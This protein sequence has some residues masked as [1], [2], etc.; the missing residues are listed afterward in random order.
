M[1][2]CKMRYAIYFTPPDRN[3]LTVMAERW[4]GRS[5]FTEALSVP[6]AVEE[7]SQPAIE[8]YTAEPRRYGFHA[9]LKAP[10]RLAE[11][12]GEAE[13]DAAL[14]VFA[15]SR[16]PFSQKMKISR[17]GQFFAI[18]PDGASPAVDQ[19]ANEIV[20]RFEPFR[21]PLTPSEIERRNPDRLSPSQLRN[22]QM[23]GYPHVFDD[24]RFHITLTGRVPE[25]DAEKMQTVLE[26][27]F[28]PLLEE[29]LEIGTLALFVEQEGSFFVKS[30]HTVGGT[31]QKR[32]FA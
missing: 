1:K 22:L 12:T 30:I 11:N 20:E 5:A 6:V 19:L 15:A 31:V 2:D 28:N 8:H 13:L 32:K 9:T 18:V 7:F 3:P 26:R 21:A 29:P 4:L 10:F 23:W 16:A 17:L 14:G 25:S 27:L 24:F